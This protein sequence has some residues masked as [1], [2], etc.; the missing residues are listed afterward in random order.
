MNQVFDQ[1]FW[2]QM[3]RNRKA[4]WDGDPNPLLADTAEG[5]TPGTALDVG[6]GEGADALWL[7]RRGWRVTATDLSEVA[8]DRARTAD[9]DHHVT[10]LHADLLTWE[11]PAETFDLVSAHFLH[12]P[13]AA[14]PTFFSRL[15][16]AVRPNGL[17]LFVAHHPSDLENQSG[18]PA[19][20]DLYFTAEEVAALLVPDRWELVVSGTQPR[21]VTTHDGRAL[22]I[23]DMVL[24]ARRV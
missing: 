13:P 11:P 18:R 4:A 22:T 20:P 5:L 17:L 16:Q 3:Y 19:I 2:D 6:C 10:W 21:E 8:L 1:A 14:R 7:A 15:A 24:K 9:T 23:H 12:V